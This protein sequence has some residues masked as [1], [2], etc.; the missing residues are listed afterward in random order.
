MTPLDEKKHGDDVTNTEPR[1]QTGPVTIAADA[2][3]TRSIPVQVSPEDTATTFPLPPKPHP[4]SGHSLGG[5]Y[6]SSGNGSQRFRKGGN[7][8]WEQP[9][10]SIDAKKAQR[11]AQ[12]RARKRSQ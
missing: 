1:A 3:G 7:R 6:M 5:V 12:K 10:G 8:G 4:L 9:G 11:K 2:T